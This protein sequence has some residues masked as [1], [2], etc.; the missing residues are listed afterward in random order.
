MNSGLPR[1]FTLLCAAT[2]TFLLLRG[3]IVA[4]PTPSSSWSKYFGS[5]TPAAS[6]SSARAGFPASTPADRS[7]TV[8][9]TFEWANKPGE[10]HD[11]R[12][13]LTAADGGGWK[14]KWHFDWGNKPVIY[15]GTVTGD[16]NNGTVSGTG[17]DAR[18]KRN[19]TFEGTAQNGSWTFDCFEV[20]QGKKP[21]GKGELAVQK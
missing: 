4:E 3:A 2:A 9:G 12:G 17:V 18:S 7:V 16:I 19:F 20:T 15:E 5:P 11:L 1:A 8:K 10:K 13:M 21:Q 14:V 6:G